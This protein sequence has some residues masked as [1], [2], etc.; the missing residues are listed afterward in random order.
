MSAEILRGKPVADKISEKVAEE[1]LHLN[2]I[3]QYPK[4][5]IIRVG[6]KPDDIAYERSAVKRCGMV[7]MRC[8]N[9]IL[10]GDISEQELITEIEKLNN[11]R[12][13]HGVLL[14]RPL[15]KS[16]NESFV[17][18][19]LATEKDVDGITSGAMAGVY[20]GSGKGFPPCTARACI[21]ILDYYNIQA[22]G[23]RAA[24]IGRSAVIGKP[25]SMLLLGK[26]AT[27]TICHTHTHDMKSVC[28]EADIVIAAAGR[29]KMIT[30][31]YFS[32]EQV[33]IDVGINVD[34]SGNMTGDVDSDGVQNNVR[35]LTPVPGGVGSVT[36]AVLCLQTL[37]AAK[38]LGEKKF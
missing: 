7:G 1:I 28:R 29:S 32:G 34:A 25:V 3:G 31:D 14:L 38:K 8:E 12:T 6:E 9:I 13:V 36:T 10:P 22:D 16:I 23:K 17:I 18:E 2:Q 15:P 20:S 24:V 35:A 4:L 5:A 21:E 30:S 11:D 27:V 19:H 37:E 33:V 26:N